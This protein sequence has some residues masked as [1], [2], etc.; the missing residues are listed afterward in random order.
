MHYLCIFVIVDIVPLLYIIKLQKSCIDR[1]FS[2]YTE[3]HITLSLV[4]SLEC[5]FRF[6][7]DLLI[8]KLESST[9][10]PKMISLEGFSFSNIVDN[11]GMYLCCG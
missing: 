7:G 4:G 3:S 2:A 8:F 10:L 9:F 6:R 11:V 5:D 1:N